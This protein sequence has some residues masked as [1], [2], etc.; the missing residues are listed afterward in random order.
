MTTPDAACVHSQTVGPAPSL[1]ITPDD[2]SKRP[3]TASTCLWTPCGEFA[4]DL[5]GALETEQPTDSPPHYGMSNTES[6]EEPFV[7]PREVD[8]SGNP[9]VNRALGGVEALLG[10]HGG[11]GS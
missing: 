9:F 10:A 1:H 6:S 11:S 2:I 3:E 8:G 4:D 5:E 7:P